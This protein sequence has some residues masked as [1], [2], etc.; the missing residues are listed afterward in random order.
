MHDRLRT[1]EAQLAPGTELRAGLERIVHGRTGAI[2]VLGTSPAVQ[3]ISTGGFGLD[4]AFSATNLRELAKM[5]G[6][7]VVS[8]DLARI[9]AAGVHLMPDASV[10]TSEVGTRHRTAERVSRQTTQAVVTVSASMATIALYLDGTRHWVQST[11]QLLILAN[12]ALQTLG[13]YRTRLREATARLSSLEV[14]DEVTLRDVALVAQRLTMVDRLTGELGDYVVQLGTDGRLVSLQLHEMTAGLAE[15]HTLLERDYDSPGRP[16]TLAA[17]ADLSTEDLLNP[18]AVAVA[19]GFD[20]NEPLET[21]LTGRG[22]RQLAQITQIP[23]SLSD[24]LIEH[25]GS[26]QQLFG[27]SIADLRGVEGVGAGRALVIRDGLER[28]ADASYLELASDT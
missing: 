19:L 15:L 7:I 14:Q 2:I 12:Q 21:P 22:Y 3:Q 9:L 27:A 16:F 18:N 20:P 1:Y 10:P 6:A 24:R 8:A 28:L 4:V 26:L 11:E 13:R 5:D 23:A 17:L 25:F